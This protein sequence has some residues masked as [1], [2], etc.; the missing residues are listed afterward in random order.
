VC[1]SCAIYYLCAWIISANDTKIPALYFINTQIKEHDLK[2]EEEEKTAEGR[3]S[4]IKELITNLTMTIVCLM[5]FS[6][7][8]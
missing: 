4:I 2:Y 5:R 7:S 6:F 8:T 1:L 3:I